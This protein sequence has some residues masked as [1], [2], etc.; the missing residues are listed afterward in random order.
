MTQLLVIREQ[1]KKIC[2][3]YEIYLV[4]I[5]KFLT[6]M[7]T[8]LV[9]NGNLGYMSKI[10]KFPIVLILALLCSFLP[11]NFIII[12]GAFLSLAHVYALSMECALIVGV[13][14]LL[15][16]LLY[17]RF[18]PKDTFVV[19][20]TPI[21]CVL[22][23]PYA[24]PLALGL[25][26]TPASA[27]SVSCGVIVYHILKYIKQSANALE[28]LDAD[29]MMSKF[30]YLIDGIMGN[31]EMFVMVIAFAVTVILVYIVRRMNIDHAW[32]IAMIVG[33]LADILILLIGDLMYTTNIS[34][35]GIILGSVIAFGVVKIIQFFV[36]NLDYARTERVQFEDDEYY[37]YV[38]AVPKVMISTP[39][40]KVKKVSGKNK[41][42]GS[43]FERNQERV[44]KAVRAQTG[45]SE[46]ATRVSRAG[47]ME[48]RARTTRP[49]SDGT[50]GMSRPIRTRESSTVGSAGISRT[51]NGSDVRSRASVSAGERRVGVQDS[52]AQR[53]LYSNERK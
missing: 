31:K 22:Q 18:S 39:E 45:K 20:L 41:E 11:L 53:N 8:F 27:V 28:A 30:K 16:F 24:I 14:Y 26:G 25:V 44:S 38:K 13:L 32:T 7:V 33:G 40:V 2:G 35:I 21:C 19:I 36:F 43:G 51:Q 23:V 29:G 5:A 10:A 12:C 49:Q 48:G 47:N 1:L 6:A 34:I 52:S 46:S 37:Y 4:P 15:M 17:F 3:K 50:E 42:A 9:I